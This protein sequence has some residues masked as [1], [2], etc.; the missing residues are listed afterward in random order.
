MKKMIS[1]ILVLAFLMMTTFA[2]AG[3]GKQRGIKG[4]GE[5]VRTQTTGRGK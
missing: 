1:M 4:N 3:G 2:F 5:V